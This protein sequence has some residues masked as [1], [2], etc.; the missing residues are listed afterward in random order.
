MNKSEPLDR[1]KL[2]GMLET[3]QPGLA[4][5]D[6]IEQATNFVFKDGFVWSFNDEIAVSHPLPANLELTGAVAAEPLLKLLAKSSGD[7]VVLAATEDE[8]FVKC[9]KGQAGI[10]FAEVKLPVETIPMPKEDGWWKTDLDFLEKLRL[11]S[12][13]VERSKSMQILSCVSI[14]ETRALGCDNFQLTV[15]AFEKPLKCFKPVLLQGSMLRHVLPFL[16]N[17]VAQVG[18][19]IHF[20]NKDDVVLSCRITEGEY[21]D[22]SGFLNVEGTRVKLPEALSDLL[23][24]A[25]VFTDS[26]EEGNKVNLVLGKDGSL[27][28]SSRNGSGWF[29]ETLEAPSKGIEFQLDV[30]PEILRSALKLGHTLVVGKAAMLMN[31]KNFQHVISLQ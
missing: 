28:V 15:A 5:H 14:E 27:K 17:G 21:P 3:L 8:L 20:I 31:G 13:S 6:A 10:A 16:P 26:K 22:V 29:K 23:E 25:G 12:L 2:L 19:W 9:G 24:R 18:N 11:A 30:D 7:T 4:P 1:K